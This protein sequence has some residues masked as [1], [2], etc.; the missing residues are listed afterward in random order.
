[1]SEQAKILAE[2]QTIIMSILTSGSASPQE[3]QRI[4]ELEALLHQQ[5]CY[6][7]IENEK[8]DYLGEEIIGLF[9]N[10]HYDEALNKIYNTQIMPEDFFGFVEYH[11]EEEEFVKF[12]TN[13][14]IQKVTKEYNA[15]SSSL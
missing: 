15:K 9:V 5:K 13:S 7:P 11:D 6:T 10:D 14:F 3:G 8:Y 12:F 1:M 4:D 2:M